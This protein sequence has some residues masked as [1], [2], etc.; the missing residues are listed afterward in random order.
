MWIL[1]VIL[2]SWFLKASKMKNIKYIS[3]VKYYMTIHDC[4]IRIHFLL[5]AT[6]YWIEFNNIWFAT[7][8]RLQ[9]R[10]ETARWYLCRALEEWQTPCLGCHLHWCICTLVHCQ[11]HQQCWGWSCLDRRKETYFVWQ[12][13][14]K[15]FLCAYYL[16]DIWSHRS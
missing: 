9:S 5:L 7:I 11:C 4:R 15:P 14:T 8:R 10:W 16:R 13:S 3:F 12:P 2:Y 6:S 1:V